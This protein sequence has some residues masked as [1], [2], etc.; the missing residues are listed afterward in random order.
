MKILYFCAGRDIKSNTNFGASIKISIIKK[1]LNNLNIEAKF[2]LLGDKYVTSLT[3][4]TV[5]KNIKKNK[6][7]KI[8]SALILNLIF[9]IK[10]IFKYNKIVKE[11]K[12]DIIIERFSLLSINNI[13]FNKK[14]KLYVEWIGPVRKEWEIIYKTKIMN[15]IIKFYERLIYNRANYIL[16]PSYYSKNFI[17]KKY[18]NKIINIGIGLDSNYIENC[19]YIN[20]N[21]NYKEYISICYVGSFA[22]YHNVDILIKAAQLMEKQ[23]IN[24]KYKIF[25]I[26]DG[27]NNKEVIR[28]IEKN[29]LK[30]IYVL[31]SKNNDIILEYL[32]Q[33]DIA[34]LPGSTEYIYPIKILE[35]AVT[36]NFVIAPDLPVIKEIIRFKEMLFDKSSADDLANKILYA[37]NNDEI[38]INL[39]NNLFEEIYQNFKWEKKWERLLYLNEIF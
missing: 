29:K 7:I 9:S 11:Y 35:Y 34:I 36:K 28:M 13:L 6:N 12:P 21:H 15:S 2:I 37:I 18:W 20:K 8:I 22:Y 26:G 19:K 32:K 31:G 30:N 27:G 14:L 17:E 3:M 16:M 24:K 23:K 1:I 33:N 10:N 38:R 5:N 25:L 4:K 39:A